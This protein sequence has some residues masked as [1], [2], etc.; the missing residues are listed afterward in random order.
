MGYNRLIS[1]AEG[2]VKLLYYGGFWGCVLLYVFN[3]PFLKPISFLPSWGGSNHD[4]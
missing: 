1:I 3:P 2:H 4:Y